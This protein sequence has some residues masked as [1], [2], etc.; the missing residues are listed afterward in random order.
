MKSSYVGSNA[1]EIVHDW[2][3]FKALLD[4]KRLL[5]QY[6][7]ND[8]SWHLYC[9]ESNVVHTTVLYKEGA[10]VSGIPESNDADRLDFELNYYDD[11]NKPLDQRAPDGRVVTRTTIASPASRTHQRVLVVN[12]A[13]SDGLV[14]RHPDGSD[15]ADV[16][17]T[18][19]D[20]NGDVTTN[21]AEA[22]QTLVD[23]EAPYTQELVG[24]RV[25]IDPTLLGGVTGDWWA[26]A[27]AAP[28]IPEAYG[29]SIVFISRMDL[30]RISGSSYRVD[31]R[32]T[33]YL[34]PDPVY[35]SNLIRFGFEH[36]AGAV[37]RFQIYLETFR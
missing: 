25:D 8:L 6:A 26:W 4:A 35:H 2:E 13:S 30:E 14:C 34:A 37:K 12:T 3:S 24:G 29:G 1:I 20:A 10:P 36:P 17:Y 16:T 27:I 5:L 21:P 28:G 22:V 7:S 33:Q 19:L 11:A 9:I 32:S 15:Y 31:G 18:L 23:F